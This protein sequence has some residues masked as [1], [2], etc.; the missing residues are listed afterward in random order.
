[1]LYLVAEKKIHSETNLQTQN[2]NKQLFR[3]RFFFKEQRNC[4]FSSTLGVKSGL[5]FPF[6]FFLSTFPPS[7]A[8]HGGLLLF[9]EPTRPLSL[10]VFASCVGVVGPCNRLRLWCSHW[11]SLSL[12]SNGITAAGL[13]S[14]KSR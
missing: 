13:S 12:R 10:V 7:L 11:L 1:M 2:W 9:K 6:S 14:Y 3:M 5:C 8:C 4:S